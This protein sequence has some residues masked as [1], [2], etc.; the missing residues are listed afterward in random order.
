[1]RAG[2]V[3]PQDPLGIR[4]RAVWQQIPPHGQILPLVVGQPDV[5]DD[6]VERIGRDHNVAGEGLVQETVGGIGGLGDRGPVTGKGRMG[7][8]IH[9]RET[10][11]TRADTRHHIGDHPI[12]VVDVGG[13]QILVLHEHPRIGGVNVFRICITGLLYLCFDLCVDICLQREDGV[14]PPIEPGIPRER[15]GLGRRHQGVFLV[16]IVS[17]LLGI[18][19]VVDREV[20]VAGGVKKELVVRPVRGDVLS[21]PLAPHLAR[22]IDHRR[23]GS[24]RIV[25]RGV[26]G[27]DRRQQGRGFPGHA[28]TG[29]V[30]VPGHRQI[31]DRGW[32]RRRI[33]RPVCSDIGVH[34]EDRPPGPRIGSGVVDPRVVVGD[35]LGDMAGAQACEVVRRP[36]PLAD[37]GRRGVGGVGGLHDADHDAF[38]FQVAGRHA[39]GTGG[40]DEHRPVGHRGLLEEAAFREGRGIAFREGQFLDEPVVP[41]GHIE[42]RRIGPAGVGGDRVG[43][44]RPRSPSKRRGE[45]RVRVRVAVVLGG[46]GLGRI[47]QPEPVGP[48][49]SEEP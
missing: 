15:V 19:L 18:G 20:A 33:A 8:R 41:L 47:P 36:K 49:P 2:T 14:L 17:S 46:V 30:V 44:M 35:G 25:D 32:G 42:I 28:E 23:R 4:L 21:D 40:E 24:V 7:G 11:G 1:M 9:G 37:D 5:P 16:W 31:P 6:E 34:R 38:L 26:R 12:G 3:L 13:G 48:F 45:G 39:G 43:V 10:R 22:D 27:G 29:R